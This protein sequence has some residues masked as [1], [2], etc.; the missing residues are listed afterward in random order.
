VSTDLEFE[1]QDKRHAPIRNA[2]VIYTDPRY[3]IAV[4]DIT[5]NLP[6]PCAGFEIADQRP[7]EAQPVWSAGFPAYGDVPVF[8]ITPGNVSSSAYPDSD[9]VKYI[10][11]SATANHGSSGGPL[12]VE[13]DV[14][15]PQDPGGCKR[16]G[17]KI[18]GMN[19]MQVADT[20]NANVA[21]PGEVLQG[22]ITSAQASQEISANPER[23]KKE[24]KAAV[25]D[26]HGLPRTTRVFLAPRPEGVSNVHW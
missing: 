22:A 6:I 4:I 21:I 18:A 19:K 12:L 9:G 24:L 1:G 7:T 25:L 16:P 26:T 13:S 3:D 8:A 17:Y 5:G 2:P 23:L 10:I 15:A 11:H 14:V 20:T